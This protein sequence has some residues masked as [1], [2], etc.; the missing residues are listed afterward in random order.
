MLVEMLSLYDLACDIR[1]E[2][3]RNR[4][5]LPRR[6]VRWQRLRLYAAPI[7][8]ASTAKAAMTA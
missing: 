4:H 7:R 6:A 2:I 8:A 1:R 3:A 5:H